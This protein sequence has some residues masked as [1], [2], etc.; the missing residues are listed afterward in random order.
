MESITKNK[1]STETISKMLKKAF[2]EKISIDRE[3][4]KELTEGFYNVAYEVKL[5][6]KN[7]I[8]KIAPPKGAKV[9][10][11]EHNIMKTEVESMRLVK[12]KTQ[13]PVPQI[14]FYDDSHSISDSD[15]FLM[16]KLE[17]ENFFKLRS[18]GKLS[19]E[20]QNDI[21]YN[22]GK[23]NYEINQLTGDCFGYPGLPQKQSKSWKEA[24]NTMMEDVLC[25]GEAID[26]ALCIGYDELRGL[27]E[28]AGFSLSEVTRPALVHWDLWEGNVFIKDGKIAGII[29]FERALWGDPLIEFAF[30]SHGVA[31]SF[32]EGYGR[33]LRKEAPIRA[34]LY[35]IYLF[36]I[37][38]IET[39]YRMYPDDWM[40]NYSI[41]HLSESINELKSL[42]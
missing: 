20:Q 3:D 40:Y 1:K 21:F 23:Y 34:T 6:D 39:K 13:V 2:G 24:F 33:N 18:E 31:E 37:M 35:D 17:G 9:M 11:Y 10:T 16:E 32:F 15:Y 12:Q 29:D 36:S 41:K 38:T 25:D 22:I 8:L 7:I 5:P 42:L 14:F 4:I 28:M 26:M 27:I 19:D 30:R